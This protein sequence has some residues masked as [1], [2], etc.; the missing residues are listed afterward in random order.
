LQQ[1]VYSELLSVLV[2]MVGY[3][4]EDIGTEE[5]IKENNRIASIYSL[6]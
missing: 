4:V 5:K 6:G 1:G 3:P 2:C